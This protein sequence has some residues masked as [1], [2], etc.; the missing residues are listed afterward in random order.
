MSLKEELKDI[1]GKKRRF[2][3]LRISDTDAE[4]ARRL[5]SIPKPTYNSWF[6]D[7]EFVRVYRKL[8]ESSAVYQQEAIQLLRRTTQLQAALLE[9]QIIEKI[10]LEIESGEYNLIKTLLARS[11]Y[12]KIINSLDYQPQS[13]S[14]S[15]EQKL[16]QIYGN[17]SPTPLLEGGVIDGEVIETT[18][19]E[20]TEHKESQPVTNSKQESEPDSKEVQE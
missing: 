5:C 4:T 8:R 19:I 12:D 20:Q 1:E 14:L 2:L 9:K 3:L 18:C 6:K 10:K 17:Q 15:W 7:S 11:V 16:Q 13:L